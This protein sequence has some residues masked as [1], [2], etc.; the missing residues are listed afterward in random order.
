MKKAERRRHLA[1][2][3]GELSVYPKIEKVGRRGLKARNVGSFVA[4]I[5][6]KGS[7]Q[8]SHG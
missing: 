5:C 1:A 8:S 6:A 4:V 3:K 7:E 2:R